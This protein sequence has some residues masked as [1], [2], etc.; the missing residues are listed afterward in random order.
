MFFT[1]N[2]ADIR[3]YFLTVPY[4]SLQQGKI[5]LVTGSTSN[6]GEEVFMPSIDGEIS[7]RVTSRFFLRRRFARMEVNIPRVIHGLR[8]ALVYTFLI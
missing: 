4:G 6:F 3:P 2:A 5:I 8:S 7:V 1:K